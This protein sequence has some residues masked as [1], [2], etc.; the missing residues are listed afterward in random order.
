MPRMI[1]AAS[2]SFSVERVSW[3]A[4]RDALHAVRRAVFIEEQRVPEHLEW[5]EEDERACHVLAT[6][7]DGAPIGT[8][9]LKQDCYIGRMAVLQAWRGRGVGCMILSTLLGIAQKQGCSVV[10]LHAQTHALEF[11]ERFG[12]SAFGGEFDEAGIPHRQMELR[13]PQAPR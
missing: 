3:S 2:E 13:L 4:R 6:S 11:Y 9:R 10:R 8:G 1:A 12:F 7:L 5:D